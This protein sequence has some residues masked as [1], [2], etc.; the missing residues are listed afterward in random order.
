M[1][2]SIDDNAA[3]GNLDKQN[4]L[5]INVGHTRLFVLKSELVC[6]MLL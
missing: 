4:R 2:T 6:K 1:V 5:L 3:D